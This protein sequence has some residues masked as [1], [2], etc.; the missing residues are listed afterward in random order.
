MDVRTVMP[1][2]MYGRDMA[3]G[4]GYFGAELLSRDCEL[5][6]GAEGSS[7]PVSD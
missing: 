6:L 2:P 1:M 7:H 4:K 5:R 3:A